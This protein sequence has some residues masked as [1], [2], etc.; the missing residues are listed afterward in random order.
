[1]GAE[2]KPINLAKG[3]RKPL[4]LLKVVKSQDTEA[5]SIFDNLP[6]LL[7]PQ[8]IADAGLA[9]VSTI[10]DWK[11]RPAKYGA[12]DRLFEPK[13]TRGSKLK[14]RRDVLKEWVNSWNN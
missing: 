8:Q 6:V 10:Y 2:R 7:S 13:R 11:Y 5:A 1:M 4:N 14:V 9:E 3:N 12:P